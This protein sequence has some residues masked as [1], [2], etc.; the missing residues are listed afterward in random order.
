MPKM[1][2]KLLKIVTAVITHTPGRPMVEPTTSG[3]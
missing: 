3:K 2:N 1:P